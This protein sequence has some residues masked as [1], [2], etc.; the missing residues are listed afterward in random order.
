MGTLPG[1]EEKDISL[2]FLLFLSLFF[3]MLIGDAGYGLLF[4]GFTFY[5]QK[6]AGKKA[7]QEVFRLIYVMSGATIIWGVLTGTYFGSAQIAQIPFL[8]SMVI[9]QI[10]SFAE[11]NS[12][13]VMYLCFFIGVIQLTIAHLL[14]AVKVM[15]SL[16]ALGELGWI[17]ILW[18]IFFL[19]GFLVVQK[20]LSP[21]T[22][23][24]LGGG[25]LTALIFSNFQKNVL[26]GMMQTL[27]DLPLSVI[28]SFSDIMSYLRL[29]AVGF[30]SVT[31]ASS[32][33]QIAIGSGIDTILKGLLAAVVLFFGHAL[34]IT[35]GIMAVL[36]HG[37]RLNMLEFSGHLNQQWSGREYQ[38]FK[39]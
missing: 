23:P 17:A 21:A 35:L 37:V 6:K 28:G 31:V 13:F 7:P 30:A 29:F 19:A 25:L 1:Y 9:H 18:G 22:V 15:N 26:K 27:V 4:L 3:A 36:V 12:Q 38:P 39:E 8:N 10:D 16:R 11:N 32:F 5:A 34:N 33:N 14:N 24:L 2:W 20:P